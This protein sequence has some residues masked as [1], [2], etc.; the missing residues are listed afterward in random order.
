MFVSPYLSCPL[1]LTRILSETRYKYNFFFKIAHQSQND[2]FH[3]FWGGEHTYLQQSWIDI[4]AFIDFILVKSISVNDKYIN[5]FLSSK[6]LTNVIRPQTHCLFIFV[7][8]F[9]WFHF[10][11]VFRV[12]TAVDW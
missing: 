8:S 7:I 4:V 3:I 12:Y 1:S 10:T 11:R 9:E 6:M 5:Y 2:I